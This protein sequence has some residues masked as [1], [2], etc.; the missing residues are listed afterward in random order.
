M[1]LSTMTSLT[2][3][4]DTA[5]HVNQGVGELQR[6]TFHRV[7]VIQ[8]GI[9]IYIRMCVTYGG[10]Q[11]NGVYL[12]EEERDHQARKH[13]W[14]LLLGSTSAVPLAVPSNLGNCSCLFTR[15]V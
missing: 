8:S 2:V 7:G 5:A 1:I 10:S 14:P 4:S 12:T 13:Y 9:R 15:A 3:H 11:R 6:V